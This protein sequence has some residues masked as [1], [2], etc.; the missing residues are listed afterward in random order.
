VAFLVALVEMVMR[1]FQVVYAPFYS[2]F[3][4]GSAAFLLERWQESRNRK[5]K[6][7]PASAA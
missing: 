2:L 6:A 3:L 1:L 5:A 4:V 7:F